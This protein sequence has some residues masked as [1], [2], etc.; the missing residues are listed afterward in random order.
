M[1]NLRANELAVFFRNNHFNTIF[2]HKG[3]LYLLVTDLG[4]LWEKGV[5]WEALCSVQGDTHFCTEEFVKYT[6]EGGGQQSGSQP[7]A[8]LRLSDAQGDD[9]VAGHRVQTE[10]DELDPDL[11]LALQLQDEEDAQHRAVCWWC[12]WG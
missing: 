2:S 8:P 12:W 1:Q 3:H 9:G 7:Q 11:L 5:V 4:F 10:G 6:G